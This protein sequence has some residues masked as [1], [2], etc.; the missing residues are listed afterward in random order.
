MDKDTKILFSVL[1]LICLVIGILIGPKGCERH[2]QS[3]QSSAYGSDW[4]VVQY[5][6]TGNPLNIW[7]LKNKSIGN[8]ASSDGIY[9]LD[10]DGNVVHLSG[11]YIYVQISG[12]GMD[13]AKSKYLKK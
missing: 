11:N 7:E 2:V 4:L 6:A 1:F 10:N 5:S 13:S 3:W 12:N 8:E 9:F